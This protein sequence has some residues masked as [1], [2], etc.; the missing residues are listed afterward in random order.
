MPLGRYIDLLSPGAHSALMGLLSSDKT[1]VDLTLNLV[2]RGLT[3]VLKAVK[4]GAL[5]H[6][7]PQ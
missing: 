5:A 1:G 7:R 6:V 2:H 3:A 4:L